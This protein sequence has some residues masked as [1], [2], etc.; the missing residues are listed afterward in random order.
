[1]AAAAAAAALFWPDMLVAGLDYLLC[2]S[3]V[4][5]RYEQEATVW[6]ISVVA[7]VSRSNHK[8]YPDFVDSLLLDVIWE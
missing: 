7:I 8:V 1:M 5:V 3:D 6:V 4:V 2:V